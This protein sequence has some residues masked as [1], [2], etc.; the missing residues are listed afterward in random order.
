MVLSGRNR[1]IHAI[2]H[3]EPDVVPLF[4]PYGVLPPTADAILERPCVATSDI[5]SAKML[6]TGRVMAYR[7]AIRRDW[8]ELVER[9]KFDAGPIIY[10]T[11]YRPEAPPRMI[12]E[13]SWSIGDSIYRYRPETGVTLEVNSK[14]RRERLPAFEEHVKELEEESDSEIDETVR[15]LQVD[16]AMAK[17]W[18][19][20]DVLAYV[21]CGTVPVGASW[22]PLFL[23]CFYMR[24]ALIRR[25]LKQM[26]RR[27]IKT[28]MVAADFGAELIFI[29]G[30][31][32]YNHGPMISPNQYHSFILPEIRAQTR[33]LHRKGVFAFNS[34]DGNLWP[35]IEDYLINSGVDGMM[36]IQATA[37]MDLKKLKELYGEKICFTGSVDC[38]FTLVHGGVREVVDETKKVIDILSPGGGH[39]LSSSNSIHATVKPIF[40][41]TM[42]DTARKYGRYK[43]TH[44]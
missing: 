10:G 21:S 5:R 18:R 34:S 40:F 13:Y 15:N 42:L 16:E 27:V 39:I 43:R 22:L 4:E 38:Q 31:I 2:C 3:E 32:A 30:D 17:L 24:P 14:I 7:R 11:Y 37:G 29:G 25:Y 33:A 26:T 1:V 20:L 8:Y 36:E 28:G 41:F 35:I 19:N 23:K 6:A 44:S 9:L 12:G